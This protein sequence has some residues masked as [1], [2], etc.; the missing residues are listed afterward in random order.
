L[1]APEVALTASWPM[2]MSTGDARTQPG[3]VSVSGQHRGISRVPSR[4]LA[5]EFP[6]LSREL[7][8]PR[9]HH[10]LLGR[11]VDRTL[12]GPFFGRPSRPQSPTPS[13]TASALP[14]HTFRSPPFYVPLFVQNFIS[15]AVVVHGDDTDDHNDGTALSRD[16]ASHQH[17]PSRHAWTSPPAPLTTPQPQNGQDTMRHMSHAL[18]LPRPA[19]DSAPPALPAPHWSSSSLSH[20]EH[21]RS[22]TAPRAMRACNY[23]QCLLNRV[24]KNIRIMYYGTNVQVD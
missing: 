17:V 24:Q 2:M 11:G 10:R 15:S 18:R 5:M 22:G 13:M 12:F 20:N 7:V 21:L 19:E 9:V 4:R 6:V 14:Y 1:S 3:V 16:A 23:T 8:A